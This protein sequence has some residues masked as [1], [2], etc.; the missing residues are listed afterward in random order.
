M[1]GVGTDHMDAKTIWALHALEFTA[2]A[3]FFW[4]VAAIPAAIVWMF[5]QRLF[6]GGGGAI[7]TRILRLVTRR[8]DLLRQLSNRVAAAHA[9]IAQKGTARL[10]LESRHRALQRTLQDER[11]TLD[12]R[13]EAVQNSAAGGTDAD[14]RRLLEEFAGASSKMP[15]FETIEHDLVDNTVAARHARS[16]AFT[17][18]VMTTLISILNWGLVFLFLNEMFSD[19]L[20]PLVKI[21]LALP[22]ALIVPAFECGVGIAFATAD[23]NPSAIGKFCMRAALSLMTCV[24]AGIEF[25]MFTSLVSAGADNRSASL[26]TGFVGQ[27]FPFLG[28]AITL[29]LV[30]FSYNHARASHTARELGSIRNLKRDLEACN[31]FVNGLPGRL[32]AIGAAAV[33]ATR[34]VDAYRAELEGRGAVQEQIGATMAEHRRSLLEAIDSVNPAVWN[35]TP[36]AGEGDLA[37]TLRV[38]WGWV[39]ATLVMIGVFIIG[40]G[41]LLQTDGLVG[42]GHGAWPFVIAALV[43]IVALPAGW[44]LLDRVG[45]TVDGAGRQSDIIHPRNHAFRIVGLVVVALIAIALI[46]LGVVAHSGLGLIES[47]FLVAMFAGLVL[48]GGYSDHILS[49]ADFLARVAVFMAVFAARAGWWLIRTAALGLA[50]ALC[51]LIDGAVS[52]IAWPVIAI[53]TWASRRRPATP[54]IATAG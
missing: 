36:L 24:L 34:S 2:F 6:P 52:L 15:A 23:H 40:G 4:F 10:L 14:L 13:L 16:G 25:Y 50:A 48:L 5:L 41:T 9:A 27:I 21:P 17:Y 33:A 53:W 19:D 28:P 7:A 43:A 11:K 45:V 47:L 46:S 22:M 20:I 54:A 26:L 35:H 8:G 1:W 49:G 30:L 29:G 51:W 44:L 12:L 18:F 37:A 32:Q 3:I 39:P 31:G 38:A 42:T